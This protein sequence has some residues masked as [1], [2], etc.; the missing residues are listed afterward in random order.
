MIRDK[1]IASIQ[2]LVEASV[3]DVFTDL[4]SP[5]QDVFDKHFIVRPVSMLEFAESKDFLGLPDLFPNIRKIIFLI[6]RPNIR[7]VYLVLGKGS[8]KS[9]ILEIVSL[10]GVYYWSCLKD[11]FEYFSLMRTAKVA[12]INVSSSREQARDVVFEGCIKLSQRSPYFKDKYEPYKN[13]IVFKSGITLYAGH[14]NYAAWLGYASF[15]GGMDETEYM[16][17]SDN[18]SQAHQLYSALRGSLRTRFPNHYKLILISSTKERLGFL[19][20]KAGHVLKTGREID[21]NAIKV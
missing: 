18:R 8:G 15:Y 17:D 9:T 16:V 1:R 19:V 7:E 4:L 20:K 2:D 3:S 14:G 6:D 5:T 10:Y 13:Y 11:P 12:C 21:F